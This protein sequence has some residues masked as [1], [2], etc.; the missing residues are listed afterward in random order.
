[1]DLCDKRTKLKHDK[2]TI[3]DSEGCKEEDDTGRGGMDL[4]TMYHHRQRD[5]RRQQ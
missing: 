1:M 3:M 5:Y 2:Y 4:G